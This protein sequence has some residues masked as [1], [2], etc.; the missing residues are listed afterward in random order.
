VVA[1]AFETPRVKTISLAVPGQV[2]ARDSMSTC[3]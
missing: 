3:G 2:I 1:T